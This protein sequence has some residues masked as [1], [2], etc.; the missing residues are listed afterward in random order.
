MEDILIRRLYMGDK[1]YE[2]LFESWRTWT[3]LGGK[4]GIK[5]DY[6]QPIEIS[7]EDDTLSNLGPPALMIKKQG[8]KKVR[9]V[10]YRASKNHRRVSVIGMIVASQ[11]KKPCIVDKENKGTFSVN[12]SAVDEKFRGKGYGSMMYGLLMSHLSSKGI[13]I[14]SDKEA[15]TSASAGK[16]WDKLS[17][18]MG[19]KKRK[20][21][22]GNDTFD[23]NNSTKDDP[24]DDC[25][26]GASNDLE[27]SL[28]DVTGNYGGIRSSLTRQ[29]RKNLKNNS[30][31]E[32]M[33]VSRSKR[34]F[35]KA[36]GST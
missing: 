4:F 22:K 23:T 9:L 2:L 8:N 34:L 15:S 13:G 32:S 25:D 30:R 18:T 11:T 29:H 6:R 5:R 31:I 12:Y 16:I 35:N 21:P 10:L 28:I 36:Y 1:K 20:T 26:K 24:M 3:G 33:L 14:T 27:H 19:I 7:D 17:S